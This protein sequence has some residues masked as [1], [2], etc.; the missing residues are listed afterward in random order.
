MNS[1]LLFYGYLLLQPC[2]VALFIVALGT[3]R[4]VCDNPT[5]A[6]CLLQFL[7]STH[8]VHWVFVVRLQS[9]LEGSRLHEFLQLIW[10]YKTIIVLCRMGYS[11][12]PHLMFGS[13]LSLFALLLTPN[14]S[15][16]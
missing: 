3:C 2:F 15:P 5:D 7:H 6:I 16:K 13:H 11:H 12:Q 4:F 8:T 14:V 1:W 10:D 9:M